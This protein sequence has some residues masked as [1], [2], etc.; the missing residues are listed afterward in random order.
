MQARFNEL[1]IW[2]LTAWRKGERVMLTRQ[3]LAFAVLWG[4]GMAIPPSTR[5]DEKQIDEWM[6][7]TW[8]MGIALDAPDV[9]PPAVQWA[10]M[11]H[12][13]VPGFTARV[14]QMKGYALGQIGKAKNKEDKEIARTASMTVQWDA[15]FEDV[16]GSDL[17][18]LTSAPGRY[19][20]FSSG[21]AGGKKWIVTKIVSIKGKPACWCLPVE[22][23]P[24]RKV[25]V[26]LTED[27]LFDLASAYEN[28]MGK[29]GQ[30]KAGSAR[31][32]EKPHGAPAPPKRQAITDGVTAHSPAPGQYDQHRHTRVVY[33]MRSKPAR[34]LAET[35]ER[36]IQV[37][38]QSRRRSPFQ[39]A[40]VVPDFISN[41]LVISGPPEVVAEVRKLVEQLDPPEVMVRVEFAL[42][43]VPSGKGVDPKPGVQATA[44]G[45]SEVA[46]TGTLPEG[47]EVVTQG[48]L[49]TL[50]G[51][52]AHVRREGRITAIDKSPAGTFNSVTLESVGTLIEVEPYVHAD[53]T[54]DVKIKL[55]ESRHGPPEEGT[56][57]SVP[58]HGGPIRAPNLE[59]LTMQTTARIAD[60]E[61]AVIGCMAREPKAGKQCVLLVTPHILALHTQATPKREKTS[62]KPPTVSP[63]VPDAVERG[64]L[65]DS[66]K[67]PPR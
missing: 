18:L 62:W 43:E 49:T 50:E 65:R 6:R 38:A 44:A 31:T 36:V 15:G 32:M 34:N 54:V 45:G 51:Q 22:V 33:E 55:E 29:T 25:Q 56:A 7:S 11:D 12:D 61:T 27:N 1:T 67:S 39:D 26:T 28:A 48:E 9:V 17:Y 16:K 52:S 58:A 53:R 5:A 40:A 4:A 42:V 13:P 14:K 37:E 46:R 8:Q 63:E 30:E 10:V 59:T 23:T 47:A 24:G 20:T 66:L 19:C 35:M 60:G 2:L 21:G 41:S 57:I 64:M 3:I